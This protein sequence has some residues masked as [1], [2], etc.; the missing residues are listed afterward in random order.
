VKLKVLNEIGIASSVAFLHEKIFGDLKIFVNPPYEIAEVV[1]CYSSSDSMLSAMNSFICSS[2]III[3]HLEI[4]HLH[5]SRWDVLVRKF[6]FYR[7]I[8]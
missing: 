7:S 3:I 2:V 4:L 5:D 1:C 6:L 8:M